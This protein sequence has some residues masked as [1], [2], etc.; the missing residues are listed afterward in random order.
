MPLFE[1][2][3][4]NTPPRL[5]KPDDI[6]QAWRRPARNPQDPRESAPEA[7][8]WQACGSKIECHFHEIIQQ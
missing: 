7:C 6:Q 3:F 8:G 2:A 5:Q 4:E 1:L